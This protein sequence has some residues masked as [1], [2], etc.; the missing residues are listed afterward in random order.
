MID[1]DFALMSGHTENEARYSYLS[2]Q[3]AKPGSN[4]R[5]RTVGGRLG[6]MRLRRLPLAMT[7]MVKAQK[8]QKINS[9]DRLGLRSSHT[10]R[11]NMV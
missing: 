7:P 6:L 11:A 5:G 4:F 10:S 9:S 8:A 3:G 2:W 1:R